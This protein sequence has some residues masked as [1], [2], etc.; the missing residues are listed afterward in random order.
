MI[1]T[2]EKFEL[3]IKRIHDLL[4]DKPGAE[5]IWNDRIADPDNPKQPRQ[6]DI[7][8]RRNN[9]LTLVECRIHK[10]KQDVKWIEE[11]IGRR[12]SLRANAVIAVSA[13][14]F[15]EGAIAKAQ[16]YG[17]ILRDILSLTEEEVSQWGLSTRVW[18]TYHEYSNVELAFIFD[19]NQNDNINVDEVHNQINKWRESLYEAFEKFADEIDKK[20]PH[21]KPSIFR[22]SLSCKDIIVCEKPVRE[23]L[24]SAKVRKRQRK[25]RIPSIVVYDAPEKDALER[26]VFIEAVEL[27]N[28]EITQSFNKACVA[29]DISQIDTPPN[30][31]FRYVTFDFKRPVT[32]KALYMLGKPQ[33][34]IG[35]TNLLFRVGYKKSNA[36]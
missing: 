10:E 16:A 18:L 12:M 20:N 35:L 3:Q 15:T 19:S 2:C 26:N 6:I 24:I 5:V 9:S 21:I 17:I 29:I 28:F 34:R 27:G 25:L 31:I 32:M 36:K 23:I 33:F 7:S 11:L 8:I 22:A 13:S 30:C 1:K 14:G 4:L